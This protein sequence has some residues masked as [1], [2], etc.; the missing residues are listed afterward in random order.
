MGVIVRVMVMLGIRLVLGIVDL[1]HMFGE[2]CWFGN[3]SL[4]NVYIVVVNEYAV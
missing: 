1:L 4:T 2:K 3:A